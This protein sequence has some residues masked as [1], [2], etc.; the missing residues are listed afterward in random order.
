MNGDMNMPKADFNSAP[1][2]RVR[3]GWVQYRLWE[4]EWSGMS[5]GWKIIK[6]LQE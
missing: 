4:M 6:R 1:G 2:Q 5:A 3:R